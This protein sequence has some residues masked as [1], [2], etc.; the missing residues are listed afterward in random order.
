MFSFYMSWITEINESD[1]SDELKKIYQEIKTKRGKLSNVMTVHSLNPGSMKYHM[2]LYLHLMFGSSPLSRTDRE[3]I[4]VLVSIFNNCGYC[5]QHHLEALRHYWKDEVVLNEMLDDI[6]AV[7]LDPRLDSLMVYVKKLTCV[8]SELTEKD[9]SGL[10]KQG[11]TDRGILDIGLIV[12][13]F[14]FVNRIVLG[15]GVETTS[16]EIGGYRY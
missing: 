13:Y 15:L 2:D 10:R 11:F 6:D 4:A 7:D 5:V 9:I 1:A 16:E 12:G 3:F 14:N 8:P